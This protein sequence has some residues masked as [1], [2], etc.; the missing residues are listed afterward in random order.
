MKNFQIIILIIV[1]S[2]FVSCN[3]SWLGPDP[4]SFYTPENTYVDQA[5][6][7]AI[8]VTMRKNLSY[9]FA[10]ERNP[11]AMEFAYSDLAVA[12]FQADFNR[13]TPNS[14]QFWPI[15]RLFNK[16]Y[17]FIKDANVLISRIDDISWGDETVRNR[18]VSEA[19]W[20]RAYWY[21]RLV[22]SYGD[23]PWLGSEVDGA[24]RDFKTHSRVAILGKLRLDLEYAAEWL[25]PQAQQLG[26]VNRGA[27]TQLLTKVYLALGEFELA[28]SAATTLID[29]PYALMTSRFGTDRNESFRNVLWDLHR[30]TNKNASENTET[31]YTT[32]DR[33]DGPPDA[34][35]AGA[36]TMRMYTPAWWKITDGAGARACNWD[37]PTGDTLGIG[38]ADVRS[39]NYYL[40]RLW[41]DGNT[42]WNRTTDLRRAPINWVE[43]GKDTA[44]IRGCAIGSPFLNRALSKS[45]YSD[46]NDTLDTW[47]SWPI[48]KV[49]IPTPNE[50]Q[51]RGGQSD[52]YIYRL[53]GTYLLRAEANY[54]LGNLEEAANDINRIRERAGASLISS[55]Q[56]TIDYIFDERARELYIEEPRHSEMIRVSFILAMLN[57]DGYTLANFHQKNWYHD[58][59][60]RV[61]DHY[62]APVFAWYGNV[63]DIKPHH[64]LWPIPQS[65]ITENT[66]GRVNQNLGYPG[67]ELNEPALETIIENEPAL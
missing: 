35:T 22:H 43:M 19:L 15:L 51:P 37:T 1:T 56:V 63:A 32:I 34:W 52:M 55:G 57:R 17:E 64:A 8:L 58:R 21:Y 62:H 38:N 48:Y 27:V 2:F 25:P 23:V 60:M 5:G 36:Q 42:T 20:H 10:G 53:A 61:N 45:T 39:N 16:S 41:E 47:Y 3:S 30:S 54:W 4:L 29:G 33:P 9:D 50:R 46:L 65:V 26:D 13:N 66:L 31:I 67:A 7:E 14:S 59:V 6:F 28:K 11:I 40:Y 49:Y 12:S 44:E 18:M 24:K